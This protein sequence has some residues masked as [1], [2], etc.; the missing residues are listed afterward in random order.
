MNRLK[1]TGRHPNEADS[2]TNSLEWLK[3]REPAARVTISRTIRTPMSPVESVVTL[4]I[5]IQTMK[6]N[7][8][9]V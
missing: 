6:R 5:S 7:F 3:M 2:S 9:R 1:I 8:R 4:T